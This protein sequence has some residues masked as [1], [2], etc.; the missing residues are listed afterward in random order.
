MKRLYR[1]ASICVA[2]LLAALL[3]ACAGPGS[4]AVLLPSPDGSVGQIT[5]TGTKG[6]QVLTQASSAAALDGS[7]PPFAVS[8]AQLQRDFGAAMAARP[9]LPEHFL[10]Y[11][12]QGSELTAES[13]VVLA[14]LLARAKA[15]SNLDISVIGHTDTQGTAEANEALARERANAIATELRQ[16]GLPD[17]V[18]SVESHGE[19]N[20]L[21]PTA[22]EVAEPRNRRVE[23]TLR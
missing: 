18:L 16:L 20:L 19:R 3:T 22:D 9:P 7:T 6:S 12:D 5:V 1:P 8:P 21:V 15:R 23:I 4:Y 10:L 2:L 14:K 13:K 17:V 11:F